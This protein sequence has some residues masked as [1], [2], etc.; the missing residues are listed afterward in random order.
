MAIMQLVDNINNAV[1]QN[2]TTLGIYLDL[3]QAFDAID[4]K[5]YFY[6][7]EYYGFRGVVK[8]WFKNYLNNRKQYVNY[9]DNTSDLET[10]LFG[11]P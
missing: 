4:H 3:S 5:I 9:N 6:K 7:W 8:N 10:I 1:E 2:K 11:V